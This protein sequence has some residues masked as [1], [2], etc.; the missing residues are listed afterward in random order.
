MKLKFLFSFLLLLSSIQL[1]AQLKMDIEGG[2]VLGTSYNKVRIPNAGGT[3]VNL[4][5]DLSI[6]PKI[7]YRIRAGYTIAKRHNVSLLFAPL[8]VTYQGDFDRNINFNN[9]VFLAEQPVKVHYKFNSYRLT[10]RYDIISRAR[11]QVGVGLTAKIRDADVRFK[12]ESADTHFDNL[13]FVPLVNFY[14]ALKPSYRWSV[15]LEGDALASKQGRAEDIFAG[16]AYQ[17]NTKLGIKLGYRVVEGGADVDDVYNFN[18]IN[19][20]SAGLLFTL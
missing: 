11:A 16:V 8:T 1:Y 12:S 13:G 17:V 5:E 2:L 14:V 6:N 15:I 19:Y 7:F 18:W 20:A 4:A 3:T 10:Y 9:T